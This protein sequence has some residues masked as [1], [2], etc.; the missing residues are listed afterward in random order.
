MID[1]ETDSV[2]DQLGDIRQFSQHKL[3]LEVDSELD[4]G[5][6][7]NMK[8]LC[9][10]VIPLSKLQK[11]DRGID[12]FVQLEHANK[13]SPKKG[14]M[15]MLVEILFR[16]RRL[17]LVKKLGQNSKE[18]RRKYGG[19]DRAVSTNLSPLRN[20]L[21]ELLEELTHDEFVTTKF[22][23]QSEFGKGT[24]SKINSMMALF[25][26][27]E[28]EQELEIEDID[29]LYRIMDIVK[30]TD[31]KQKIQEYEKYPY[32]KGRPGRPVLPV[33]GLGPKPTKTPVRPVPSSGVQVSASD[34]E[35]MDTTNVQPP[36]PTGTGLLDSHLYSISVELAK[37]TRW[38]ALC[39]ELNINI[40]D[41]DEL[42]ATADSPAGKVY[43]MLMYWRESVVNDSPNAGRML[44]LALYQSNFQILALNLALKNLFPGVVME[45]IPNKP[46][47]NTQTGT[48][49][50]VN[51]PTQPVPPPAQGSDSSNEASPNIAHV[52]PLPQTGPNPDTQEQ[53]NI[54][55]H[56]EEAQISIIN[57]NPP[58]TNQQV[59]QSGQTVVPADGRMSGAVELQRQAVNETEQQRQDNDLVRQLQ[60][61]HVDNELDLP[62][63]KMD[64]KPRGVCV[65]INNEEFY[66]IPRDDTSKEMPN[67][68]G[69]HRDAERLTYIFQKLDFLVEMHNN[70]TDIEIAQLLSG[71]GYRDH[72]NYDCFVCCIL[73]HGASGHI[74]GSNGKMLRINI[75][76]GFFR[77]QVCPSLAGKPKLFF[78]QACQG[79]DKQGGYDLE[80]DAAVE[81]HHPRKPDLGV[82]INGREMIPDEA[83]F[84]LGYATVPGYVSYRSRSQGSWF[85][86]KLVDM[87]DKYAYRY[88]L[89]SVLVKVNEEVGNAIANVDGGRYKQIPAPLVTLRKKLYFR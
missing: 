71:V 79:R 12:L 53:A 77:S 17:D 4:S 74:F 1:M 20:L 58:T 76:T 80:P 23:L 45:P 39:G 70:Q 69:T 41:L 64:A 11:I 52:A 66:K 61:T 7:E 67:R 42:T 19:S 44:Y 32:K 2:E 22:V 50:Q 78:I 65:I 14:D 68:T 28:R 26:F 88:D 75:L 29:I 18:V 37:E 87:L 51:P 60:R 27:L 3:L 86:N 63:Y 9:Q 43:L 57:P 49:E 82:D 36:A 62:S 34:V 38:R 46:E 31:L 84:I 47:D 48:T 25:T 59:Q 30:R 35:M 5:D 54:A 10:D 15:E 24:M 81:I 83:D 40:E 56:S 6:I 73:T 16:V 21:Y 72:N 89:L 8:F 33:T 55:I 13:I 85:I